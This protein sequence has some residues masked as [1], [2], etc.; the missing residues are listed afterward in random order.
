MTSTEH[1]GEVV[2]VE[3]RGPVAVIT[4]DRPTKYNA[5]DNAVATG[6]TDALAS[7]A[8]DPRTRAVV[9]TGSGRAFAAGADIRL[10]AGASAA[11]F[12]EF[13]A[14][15]NN[16]CDRIAGSPIPVVA[17][18][19]GLALG[20]GFEL[21]LSCDVVVAEPDAAFGLPE[22]TLG[23]LPGWGGTQRLTWH[24]GP[25]RARWLIMSGERLDA[26]T[27]HSLGIVTHL[28]KADDLL[29]TAVRVATTLAEQAPQAIAAVRKSIAA[30]IPGAPAM[31]SGSGFKLE[32]ELLTALFN[33]PDGREGIAAF[34]GKRP[35]RFSWARAEATNQ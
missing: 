25:N 30:A 1:T 23:L 8:D 14:L 6:L 3:N 31:S 32:R 26:P 16:L 22:V 35:P 28:S 34:V 33:S 21:V 20:G 12:D 19:N 15:C 13:T 9:L 18:V 2:H 24:V 27:A 17:A 7:V 11:E 10:Y 29:P 4:I 5:I